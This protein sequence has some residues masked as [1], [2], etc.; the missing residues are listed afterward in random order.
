MTTF[1]DLRM[2]DLIEKF[3][4]EI[5]KIYNTKSLAGFQKASGMLQSIYNFHIT[6]DQSFIAVEEYLKNLYSSFNYAAL[7]CNEGIKKKH[8]DKEDN[9][10]LF[11]C[12]QVMLKCCEVITAKLKNNQ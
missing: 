5:E 9:E 3:N 2:I 12:L 4:A 1:E 6:A 7:I 8:L 10:L 11:E